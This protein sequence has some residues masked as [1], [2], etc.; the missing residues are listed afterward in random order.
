MA[1]ITLSHPADE[2]RA[3]Q[4]HWREATVPHTPEDAAKAA[5]EWQS[6]CND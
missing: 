5:G 3:G 6:W 4:E 1:P 2:L